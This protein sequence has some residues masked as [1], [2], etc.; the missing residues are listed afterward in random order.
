MVREAR[1]SLSIYVSGDHATQ[2]CDVLETALKA[3]KP[4]S[5]MGDDC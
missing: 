5:S 1:G 2:P 4:Y 3:V